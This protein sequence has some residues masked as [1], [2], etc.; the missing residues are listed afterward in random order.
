MDHIWQRTLND[1]FI[2]CNKDFD[3]HTYEISCLK[4]KFERST[5]LCPK[6]VLWEPKKI[7]DV[8]NKIS[9]NVWGYNKSK[10]C[11]S[12]KEDW[13]GAPM[14]HKMKRDLEDK[15]KQSG[16]SLRFHRLLGIEK[17]K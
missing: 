12:F 7:I 4:L 13:D 9:N 10:L 14:D 5:M 8:F 6:L 15:R 2:K 17:E 3:R 1:H 11:L 16:V